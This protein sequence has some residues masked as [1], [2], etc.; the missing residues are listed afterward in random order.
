MLALDVVVLLT[1][2]GTGLLAGRA[3]GL[4]AIPAYLV[5]GVVAGPGGLGLV[6]RSAALDQLAELGVALLLFGVGIEFSLGRM[7]RILPRM[8]A[9]GGTQI[10]ATIGVTALL[11]RALGQDWPVAVLIGF[12]VALSSTAIVFK[13]FD[14]SGEIDAPHGQAA[15][16]ILLLQDLALVPMMLLLPVLAQPGESVVVAT[17]TAL[18]KAVATLGVLLFVARAALPRLFAL[19]AGA[20]VSELFPLA[21]IA[22]AFGTALVAWRVGLSPPIGAFLAG[23]ALSGSRYAHQVFAEL[24]P[25]RDAFVALFFTTIGM[26]LR[27]EAL[28]ASPAFLVAIVAAVALKGL[29]VG[30]IV[31]LLARSSGVGVLT[32]AAL[33]Q[34]GEFSFVLMEQGVDVGLL[35]ETQEQAFLAAAILT[36]GATP[37]LL[38]GAHRLAAVGAD[39]AGAPGGAAS[40]RSG[41]VVLVGYG[42]T[43]QAVA[44]VLRE[45]GIPFEAVDLLAENVEA[46]RRDGVPVHFGDASRRA[47]LDQ[48]GV[49]AARAAVVAVGD[50]GATRRIV[51]QL[52]R[53]NADLR[54]LVRARR[55]GEI[56]EL[57]RLG[58]DEVIPSEFE[59]SIELFVRLLTHLG[60]PRH[61]VRMQESII[62]T[63]H[64]RALRGLG[65]TDALLA[66]TKKLVAGGILETAQVMA[67]SAAAGRTLAELDLQR[68]RGVVVLSVVRGDEPL[69]APGGRTRLETGDLVVV[70]GPH[71]SIDRALALFEPATA[72]PE[73]ADALVAPEEG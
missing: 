59:V 51:T 46:A 50:P 40:R 68:T 6:Q 21:A 73:D 42:H 14:D 2:A 57:E 11:F 9:S 1:V 30:G 20:R 54:L 48:L 12:L 39:T 45:T 16:G 29:L 24:L 69:P 5:A 47:V 33:S 7:R 60:I 17:I 63:E 28:L 23:L 37:F 38:A 43:G 41:H 3:L 53:A 58:A 64:Y 26:L 67:G 72:P 27:P 32:A 13:L 8:L 70:F 49:E 18:G 15:A 61:L 44:R 56:A 65:A 22:V 4:P 25:L 62:R 55:V 35:G 36:M 10:V 52:R 19:V 31:H 34:I 71:E 66:E